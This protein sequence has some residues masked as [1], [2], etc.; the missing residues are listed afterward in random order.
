M[1]VTNAYSGR[2]DYGWVAASCKVD[3]KKCRIHIYL[4]ITFLGIA[5]RYFRGL[6]MILMD[7]AFIGPRI[8]AACLFF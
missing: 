2:G 3:Q 5:W 8:A 1:G 4:G 7:R 6:Q